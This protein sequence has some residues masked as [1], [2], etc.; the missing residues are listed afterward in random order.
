MIIIFCDCLIVVTVFLGEIKLKKRCSL[1]SNLGRTHFF[2][3]ITWVMMTFRFH[4][5]PTNTRIRVITSKVA[6][7]NAQ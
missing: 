4:L 3:I 5:H 2:I 7:I 6:M 1:D